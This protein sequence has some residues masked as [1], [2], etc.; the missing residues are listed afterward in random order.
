MKRIHLL[1]MALI[2]MTTIT[3]AQ[4]TVGVGAGPSFPI[5]GYGQVVEP[6]MNIFNL[7]GNQQGKV[8]PYQAGYEYPDVSLR[9]RQE[10]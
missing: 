2:A 7:H 4:W 1:T 5:T 10:S 9:Q 8:W 6:G 3:Q